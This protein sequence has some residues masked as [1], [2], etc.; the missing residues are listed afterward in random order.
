MSTATEAPPSPPTARQLEI[1]AFL[2]AYRDANGVLPTVREIGEALAIKS[3]NGVMCHLKALAKKGL[4]KRPRDGRSRS[5]VPVTIC[6]EVG[7]CPTCGRPRET[8]TAVTE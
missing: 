3:P 1:L 8:E 2:V 7:C 6:R 4:L 5:W